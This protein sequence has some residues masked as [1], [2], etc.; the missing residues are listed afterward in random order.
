MK[1]IIIHSVYVILVE[2]LREFYCYYVVRVG[3]NTHNI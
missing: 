2:I 1:K 3:L